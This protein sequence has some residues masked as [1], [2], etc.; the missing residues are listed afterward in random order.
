MW[1][2]NVLSYQALLSLS[3]FSL[4]NLWLWPHT[5]L[6]V[7][8]QW[9]CHYRL[10]TS[11]CRWEFLRFKY[12]ASHLKALRVTRLVFNKLLKTQN[13]HLTNLSPAT[14][15][16]RDWGHLVAR[17]SMFV[18]ETCSKFF[19]CVLCFDY[20]FIMGKCLQTPGTFIHYSTKPFILLIILNTYTVN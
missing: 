6:L 9:V 10:E 15:H 1:D 13:R 2:Q 20:S 12:S 3:K 7:Y 4:R 8:P 16:I 18:M 17:M 14:S 11:E 5:P 19:T